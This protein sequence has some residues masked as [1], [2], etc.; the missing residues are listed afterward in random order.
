MAKHFLQCTP[1][2][3][4]GCNVCYSVFRCDNRM[5]YNLSR[6]NA[7]CCK[8][9]FQDSGLKNSSVVFET[10]DKAMQ[11]ISTNTGSGGFTYRCGRIMRHRCKC[12]RGDAACGFHFKMTMSKSGILVSGRLTHNHHIVKIS[13]RRIF[14]KFLRSDVTE[15]VKTA[16]QV[17]KP[18]DDILTEVR[19]LKLPPLVT[20]EALNAARHRILKKV[21]KKGVMTCKAWSSSQLQKKLLSKR[22]KCYS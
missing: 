1:M 11:W 8:N 15:M 12:G 10:A 2:T 17:G 4:I 14:R 6:K 13:H 9:C 22:T 3:E 16:I 21:W 20:R 19:R 18:N 5:E 7:V